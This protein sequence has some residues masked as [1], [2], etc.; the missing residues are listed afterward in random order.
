MCLKDSPTTVLH[1]TIFIVM[2]NDVLNGCLLSTIWPALFCFLNETSHDLWFNGT[3]YQQRLRKIN[4]VVKIEKCLY[5]YIL[6]INCDCNQLPKANFIMWMDFFSVCIMLMVVQNCLHVGYIFLMASKCICN[7][8]LPARCFL[9]SSQSLLFWYLVVVSY[10]FV[11]NHFICT[12][13]DDV[14]D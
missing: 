9:M 6:Q 12:R 5:N 10:L 2:Q 14:L 1:W 4:S 3:L 13:Y 11:S 7:C 8:L